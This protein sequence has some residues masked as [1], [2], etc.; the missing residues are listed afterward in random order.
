MKKW[1]KYIV[2][3]LIFVF[4]LVLIIRGQRNIGPTGLGVMLTG[5]SGL[6]LLLFCYNKKHI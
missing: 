6:L 3:A 5:L 4:C 1:I 2:F